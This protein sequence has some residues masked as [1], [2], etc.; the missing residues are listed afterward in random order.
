MVK[1][2]PSNA[3]GEGSIPGQEAKIP[4]AS[5]SKTQNIKLCGA[6]WGWG[7]GLGPCRYVEMEGISL[8]SGFW[9]QCALQDSDEMTTSETKQRQ[10]SWSSQQ[11]LLQQVTALHPIHLFLPAV[12][13]DSV[14]FTHEE[15]E[16][17]KA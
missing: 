9:G 6:A 8:P 4:H 10:H 16:A 5:K 17:Q 3:W 2:L 12:G 7:G 14:V 15:A 1:T 11:A 13:T